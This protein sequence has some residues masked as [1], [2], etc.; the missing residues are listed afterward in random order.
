MLRYQGGIDDKPA[1]RIDEMPAARNHVT[2]ALDEMKAGKAVSVAQT[3]PY[4][5]SVKYQD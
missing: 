4:V 3:V 1:A 5:C 2:A